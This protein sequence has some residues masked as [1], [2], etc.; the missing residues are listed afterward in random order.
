MPANFSHRTSWIKQAA[1]RHGFMGAGISKAQPLDEE[2]RRLEQWLNQGYH[3]EM[4]YM[5]NHF[6]LR[7]DPAKLVPGAKS[8]ISLMYNYYP[9]ESSLPQERQTEMNPLAIPDGGQMPE[10]ETMTFPKSPSSTDHSHLTQDD[11]PY[12]ISRY[13]YGEDYHHVVRRK[14][15]AL[16]REMKSEFGDFQARVFVDSGPVMERDWAKR[17]GL[18][19]IGKNTLLIDP[20]RGS[21]F[22]LAEI[23][24]DLEF[25]YDSP[26]RD[27]CGTCTRC[28]KACPTEAISPLGYILDASKCISYLTIELKTE[29]PE[30]F[31]GK[32]EGWIFGC[33]ICQE[34]CPWNRFSVPHQE[35]AFERNEPS[36]EMKNKDWQELTAELFDLV[37]SKTPVKRAGYAGIMR[38]IRHQ[39]GTYQNDSSEP[40]RPLP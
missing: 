9:A 22:F 13:A 32:M 10:D 11:V 16:L 20:R 36:R 18:G 26:I 21:Y 1:A 8:V 38:N 35:P 15:K 29:I 5:A 30:S 31:R 7:T 19:W 34:V 14:L 39:S 3:A 37:F 2:A 6:D 17:S 23:I 4:A 27:H 28:I 33:D 25:D 40:W 12:L 24:L